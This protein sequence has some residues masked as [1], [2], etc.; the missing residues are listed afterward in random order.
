MAGGY[1]NSGSSGSFWGNPYFVGGSAAVQ[2][3]GSLLHGTSDLEKAQEANIRTNTAFTNQQLQQLKLMMSRGGKIWPQLLSRLRSGHGIDPGQKNV[4]LARYINMLRPAIAS[5]MNR[6]TD[7]RSPAFQ[8]IRSRAIAPQV[9]G[10]Q[11]QLDQ[12]DIN[13][14]NAIRQLVGRMVR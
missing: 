3:L 13:Q 2:T 7:V 1:K 9:G 14:L 4:M 11:N 12:L 6:H 10:Y 5:A 8:R